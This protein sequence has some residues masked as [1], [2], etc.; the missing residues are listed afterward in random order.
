MPTFADLTTVR[1]GLWRVPDG[2]QQG[3]GAWGGLLVGAA[4]RAALAAHEPAGATPPAVRDVAMDMLGPVPSGDVPVRVERLR[5]GSSTSAWRVDALG[6]GEV[7]AAATVLL[8]AQRSGSLPEQVHVREPDAPP[9]QDV[10]LVPLAPP[11]APV[12][13]EHL[14]FR[15]VSGLPYQGRVEDVV[16]WVR[17]PQ[18]DPVDAP[19]L[20]GLVDALWPASLVTFVEPRPVATMSFSASL[21][22]DPATVSPLAPLLHVGRLVVTRDGYARETRELWTPDGRL[23]VWN[24]Q[25]MAIIR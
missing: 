2:W 15:V 17:F 23:A 13:T 3:R 22:V 21:H 14:E 6:D 12:F 4:V 9:W 16:C 18:E 7:V 10:P 11:L 19:L 5:Q 25:V 8:G 20:L 1:D 24:A